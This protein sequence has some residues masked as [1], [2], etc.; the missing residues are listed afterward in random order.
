MNRERRQTYDKHSTS[1]TVA[2][3]GLMMKERK[4]WKLSP[5]SSTYYLMWAI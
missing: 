5:K 3:V 1:E 4:A 2:H